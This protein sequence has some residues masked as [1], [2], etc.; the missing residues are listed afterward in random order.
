MKL[1]AIILILGL[2]AKAD[3]K[4]LCLIETP[5]SWLDPVPDTSNNYLGFC[6]DRIEGNSTALEVFKIDKDG[7]PLPSLKLT[8]TKISVDYLSAVDEAQLVNLNASKYSDFLAGGL[9]F[10]TEKLPDGLGFFLTCHITGKEKNPNSFYQ[11]YWVPKIE[12]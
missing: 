9:L 2:Q 4:V 6:V 12:F 8:V 11:K 1:F 5:C 3:Q 7:Q 10:K